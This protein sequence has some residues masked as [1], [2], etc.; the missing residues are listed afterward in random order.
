MKYWS[1]LGISAWIFLTSTIKF[2]IRAIKIQEPGF[3]LET[4]GSIRQRYK[5]VFF[6]I[7]FIKGHL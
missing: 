2:Q 6:P 7:K 4:E 1:Y 3:I 5:R